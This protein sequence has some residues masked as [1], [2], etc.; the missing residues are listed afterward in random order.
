MESH[1]VEEYLPSLSKEQREAYAD[2]FCEGDAYLKKLL[3]ILWEHNINTY[4]CCRGHENYPPY[5][6]F[7]CNNINNTQ[8]KDLLYNIIKTKFSQL[9]QDNKKFSTLE[10][11]LTNQN[12]KDRDLSGYE[13]TK[14]DCIINRLKTLAI[15]LPIGSD[16]TK[17]YQCFVKALDETS[18]TKV[19]NK[20]LDLAI[21]L[22]NLDLNNQ[23]TDNALDNIGAIK[24]YIN[25]D[26][27][28][29]ETKPFA[30]F[31]NDGFKALK[32]SKFLALKYSKE[33]YLYFDENNN[34]LFT[35]NEARLKKFK[36]LNIP[37][38]KIKNL[39]FRLT[40]LNV[41][42]LEHKINK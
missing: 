8:L 38:R 23:I 18:E 19:C 36:A 42:A 40:K 32:N 41:L 5:I 35:H 30:D 9:R 3:L 6:Y 37:K 17:L 27:Y 15:H 13:K 33:L 29:F 21:R 12:V 34:P 10:V 26:K 20:K 25:A 14:D 24:I 31:C 7:D 1:I 16:Y 4:A 11:I 28:S 22:M 2:E 39:N